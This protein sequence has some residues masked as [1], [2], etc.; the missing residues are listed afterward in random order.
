MNT[1][2]IAVASMDKDYVDAAKIF[3]H[4]FKYHHPDIPI[5]VYIVDDYHPSSDMLH[6]Y[7]DVHFIHLK[8]TRVNK[9]IKDNSDIINKKSFNNNIYD[10]SKI[11]NMFAYIEA[12]DELIASKKYDVIIKS[13]LDTLW[14]DSILN[15][16]S[17][18]ANSNLPIAMS[19]ENMPG[20]TELYSSILNMG[21]YFCA[22]VMLY[23]THML[24]N[25][26]LD[27]VFSTM[28]HYGISKFTYLDQDALMLSYSKKFEL[29]GVYNITSM[30]IPKAKNVYVIHYN[31]FIKPF[32]RLEKDIVRDMPLYRTY[33]LY[34]DM[35]VAV[36]CHESFINKINDN[37]TILHR[38]LKHKVR[39]RPDIQLIQIKCTKMLKSFNLLYE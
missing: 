6:M 14:C 24:T 23:N 36:N 2:C 8:A 26:V 37:I 28:Q 19:R 29:N 18:F 38:F 27:T 16:L 21:G 3:I 30:P 20:N 4:S 9:F 10:S 25:S 12:I 39:L 17:E 32:G 15:E 13:D 31:T 11:I 5:N 35:A 22:G 1:K 7:K 34:R 33:K